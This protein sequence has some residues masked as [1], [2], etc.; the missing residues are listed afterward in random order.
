MNLLELLPLHSEFPIR[1]GLRSLRGLTFDDVSILPAK[2]NVRPDMV[3]VQSTVLKG[4]V[5][6]VPVFSAPM[7]TVWSI[8][9]TCTLAEFGAIGPITRDLSLADL[10]TAIGA[11]SSHQIDLIKN[12]G[13]AHRKGRPVI[14]VAASPFDSARLAFLVTHPEVDYILLDTVHPY[15][16]AVL[17]VVE[18]FSSLAPNR[19]VIG[20]L[21]T[22][23]AAVDFCRFPIAGIKVGLGPGSICTTREIS[24]IGVPQLEAVEEVSRVAR[25][26]GVPVIADGGIRTCGDIAKA[27]AAG[28]SSVM[29]GRLF[30]GTA[31]AA[32]ETVE[33]D[34]KKY[35]FYAGSKYNS[36][37]LEANTGDRAL[38]EFIKDIANDLQ[39]RN[40][41]VEG[42]SGLTPYTGPAKALLL[43]VSRSLGASLAFTGAKTLSEFRQK[44]RF[45]QIS[46]AALSE[47]GAHSLPVVTHKN[48]FF[49]S[50]EESK[51]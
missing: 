10:E 14:V 37:E 36:V 15:N 43:Q 33:K 7:Q 17:D 30:A 1:T 32:G 41:R 25:E 28:A 4:C 48:H 8:S 6:S 29:M 12:P 16:D 27:L 50:Q 34:G 49:N 2:T 20:N 21:A 19:I 9:L 31:E 44:A 39:E 45:I 42:V 38:D 23:E 46:S 24:G 13:A 5:A 26:Y 18:K 22:A 51:C 35:K 40:H 47:G 3:S 11:I